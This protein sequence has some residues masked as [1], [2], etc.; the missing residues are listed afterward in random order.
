MKGIEIRKTGELFTARV[1]SSGS[2]VWQTVEPSPRMDI[3][4][5]LR[6]LGFHQTDI[7]DA[8]AFAEGKGV[9]DPH[10]FFGEALK[11]SE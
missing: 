6:E 7:A 4:G 2:V 1:H 11:G 5:A 3:D 10:P 9:N 8:F